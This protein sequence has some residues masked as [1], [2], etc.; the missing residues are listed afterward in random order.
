MITSPEEYIKRLADIQNQDNLKELVMLPTEEPRFIIDANSRTITI[1]D[2]FTFIGVQNDHA[3]E[4]IYFEIDRYFDQ[5]DLSTEMC[6]VQFEAIGSDSKRDEGFYPI[7]KIDIDSVPGKVIFGW[8]ILND[9]TKYDGNVCFSVRFYSIETVG[10]N[11]RFKYNFNTLPTSLPVKSSLN[12]TGEG[13]PVDPTALEIMSARFAEIERRAK[14]GMVGAEG[15]KN[16]AQEIANSMSDMEAR[17]RSLKEE[18]SRAATAANSSRDGARTSEVNAKASEQAAKQSEQNAATSE[19]AALGSQNKAKASKDAA[20]QS[21]KNAKQSELNAKASEN[22][23]LASQNAAKASEDASKTSETNA[24]NSASAANDSQ[25][26]SAASEAAALASQK[27]SAASQSAAKESADKAKA[28]EDAAKTSETN[29]ASSASTA[30][31][32]ATTA[33]TKA[34]E[35]GTSAT[36]A[37]TSEQNAANSATAAADSQTKSKA[38]ENSAA[39]YA[40]AAKQ[41]VSSKGWVWLDDENDSGTLYMYISE[42]LENNVSID[43]NGSGVLEVTLG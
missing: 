3:A 12:S 42:N 21:E 7:T 10:Y 9:V 39:E 18:A 32:A 1:P 24:A 38:S 43:D 37:A 4:T 25:V 26:A 30:T 23:A 27:A 16:Q 22:A 36:N 40:E 11:Q 41:T 17:V 31:D 34:T 14:E 8:K 29:A 28:S 5:H 33:T 6:V 15:W 13:V 2:A 19:A 20:L 35:A